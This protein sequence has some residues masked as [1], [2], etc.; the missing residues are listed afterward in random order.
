MGYTISQYTELNDLLLSKEMTFTS[1]A[2]AVTPTK[3]GLTAANSTAIATVVSLFDTSV[4]N[5]VAAEAA[6]RAAVQAKNTARLNLTE[7]MRDF[8][9]ICYANMDV[10]NE[11]LAEI[12]LA[13]R[14]PRANF[15][16]PTQVE[17]FQ[18]TALS[19]G[20]VKFKWSRSGNTSSTI[21][22]LE[23]QDANG[24][25]QLVWSGSRIRCELSGYTP[26]VEAAFR[27]VATKGDS[28]SQPSS[29]AVIYNNSSGNGLRLAA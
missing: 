17:S 15:I 2:I 24:D 11:E 23:E 29:V 10:S 16:A 22:Q 25:W 8:L 7:K 12:L 20:I 19:N 13:P 27:V 3:Y 21:F 6:Y 5:L 1:D 14:T 28:F 18:A 4:Q 26:G 9:P